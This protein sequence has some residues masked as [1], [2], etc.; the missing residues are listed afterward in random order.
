MKPALTLSVALFLAF[1]GALPALAAEVVTVDGGGWGHGIG[2]SQYGAQAM[3]DNGASAEEIVQHFYSGTSIGIAGQGAVTG[4][5]NPLRIGIAQSQTRLDF[6]PVGGE[7]QL[8]LGTGTCVSQGSAGPA[9]NWSLR[10][11]A[12]G[13]CRFFEGSTAVGTTGPCQ[14]QITW[15]NQPATKVSVPALNRLYARGKIVF[16]QVPNNSSRIHV[17]V[18]VGLEQYLYG[19]GE[20]P[21]SWQ[22]EALRAQAIAG[23]TYAV[24][25]G[26]ARN[27]ISSQRMIACGCHLYA[28]TLDQA[29]VGW[30][31]EGEG[32]GWGAKWKAAVD[33]TAGMVIIH[34][35]TGDR[36]IEAYYFSAS[37]GRTENNEDMWGG[38]PRSYL[39]STS[40]PGA[41]PWSAWGDPPKTFT[42][43]VF[44]QELGFDSVLSFGFGPKFASGSPASIVFTGLKGGVT[45]SQAFSG[46]QLRTALGLRSHYVTNIS[47]LFPSSFSRL[48][49]GNFDADSGEEVAAYSSVDGSWWVLGY[50]SG[51]LLGSEWTRFSTKSGWS[52]QL[53]GDFNEDGRDD[54]ANFHPGTGKWVVSRSTGTSFSNSVWSTFSTKSGWGSQLV[55]DFNGD[56]RDDI[57][58]YHPSNGN[59]VVSRSTG[60]GFSNSVWSTFSTKSGWTMQRVGDFNGDGLDDIA[61]YHSG[62]GNWVVSRST[63][64][65]FK[66]SVWST[67]STKSGW[68]TQRAGDF[69]G[70]GL[71]DIANYHPGTGNWVVSRSTGTGFSN[72]VWSTFSTKSGWSAQRV[73][74]FNEDGRDDIANYHPGS[75]NWVVSRSTGTGFSNAVWTTFSPSGGWTTHLVGDLNGDGRD[76]VTSARAQPGIWGLGIA[77]GSA[78]SQ[79]S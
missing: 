20:M 23:R 76:D 63:G 13:V 1:L 37:G 74:D 35:S 9:E 36:A 19:L 12:P 56:G 2:M 73:G 33:S 5:P 46:N 51:T 48:V 26:R 15:A 39:R 52:S 55:G 22:N 14:G 70:D 16:L 65:G 62:T 45:T 59:W 72:S 27:P 47:G 21:S 44:A 77:T 30:S 7:V 29:Y 69:N 18:D 11:T 17:T 78:F 79:P 61:N 4:H 34:P 10:V 32:N 60:S 54:I 6:V 75:G 42:K 68:F 25:A 71:D 3:A 50:S 58:N 49:E 38:T 43:S 31:K 40:D 53:V 41:R 66:N 24:Q 64:T 67:F 57:A 8:C 28:S